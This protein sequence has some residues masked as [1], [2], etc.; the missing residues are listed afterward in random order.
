MIDVVRSRKTKRRNLKWGPER[1][2]S[3]WAWVV[4]AEESRE[5]K[6]STSFTKQAYL[7]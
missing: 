1:Q 5:Y 7:L 6:G 4:R 3:V 2:A